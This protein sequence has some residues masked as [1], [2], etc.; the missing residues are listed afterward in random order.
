MT[1]PDQEKHPRG[2]KGNTKEDYVR[3]ADECQSIREA[4]KRLGV[5]RATV[6]EQWRRYRIP[7]PWTGEVPGL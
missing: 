5:T 2:W 7:N 3:A 4:A 6:R 1:M